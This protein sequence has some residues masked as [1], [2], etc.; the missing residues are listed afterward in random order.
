MFLLPELLDEYYEGKFHKEGGNIPTVPRPSHTDS[1]SQSKEEEVIGPK[2]PQAEEEMDEEDKRNYQIWMSK[3]KTKLYK[4]DKEV[5]LEE[6]G[7]FSC[8]I[9]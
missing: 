3:R 1:A 5:T 7:S 4:K 2:N 8:K 9:M 6:L